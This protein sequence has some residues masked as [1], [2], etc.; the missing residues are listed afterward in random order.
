MDKLY[1]IITPLDEREDYKAH[2]K[3]Q[4]QKHRRLGG[5]GMMSAADQLA[6]KKARD[7]EL[8]AEILK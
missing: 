8:K 2:V 7:R 4:E 5:P 6:L 3:G 1:N